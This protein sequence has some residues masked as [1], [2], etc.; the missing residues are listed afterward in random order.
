[1][2]P[3]PNVPTRAPGRKVVWSCLHSGPRP[4]SNCS[5]VVTLIVLVDSIS[6]YVVEFIFILFT[7]I[8]GCMLKRSIPAIFN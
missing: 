7:V 5:I 4:T 6:V 1:M 8:V 3:E 2:M